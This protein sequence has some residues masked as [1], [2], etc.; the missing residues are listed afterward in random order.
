[1]VL[2]DDFEGENIL[3]KI[4]ALFQMFKCALVLLGL[5]FPIHKLMGAEQLI[6]KI[7]SDSHHL[8]FYQPKEGAFIIDK[9]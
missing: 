1:M 4:R 2:L 5:S 7:A 3:L 6:I 9:H 8:W